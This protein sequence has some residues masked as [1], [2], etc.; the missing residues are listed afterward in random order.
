VSVFLERLDLGDIG[1]LAD[2]FSMRRQTIQANCGI[3][4]GR[5]D[6]EY[7]QFESTKQEYLK[8]TLRLQETFMQTAESFQNA[9]AYYDVS[10]MHAALAELRT[11]LQ[12]AEKLEASVIGQTTDVNSK[13]G[14]HNGGLRSGHA[15]QRVD[16][17]AG[18]Q[19]A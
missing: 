18:P 19:H 2:S 8:R 3:M 5:L 7:K 1:T 10:F 17:G 12:R 9:K 13:V 14:S 11:E 6:D 16:Q 15:L 4:E